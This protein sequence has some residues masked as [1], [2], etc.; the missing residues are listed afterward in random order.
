MLLLSPVLKP[1]IC[2]PEGISSWAFACIAGSLA[3]LQLARLKGV[4][5]GHPF[6]F[7]SKYVQR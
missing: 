3:V 7:Q 1:L 4:P 6:V 2:L 5:V